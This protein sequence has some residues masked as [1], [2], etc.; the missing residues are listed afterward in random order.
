MQISWCS[1]KRSQDKSRSH[2]SYKRTNLPAYIIYSYTL[3]QPSARIK[4]WRSS[5]PTREDTSFVWMAICIRR[6]GATRTGS[7]GSTI[8]REQPGVLVDSQLRTRMGTFGLMW[9]TTIQQTRQELR[10]PSLQTLCRDLVAERRSVADF[11]GAVGHCVRLEWIS[12]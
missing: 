9:T 6:R 7:G 8:G 5:E 1:D 10:S 12:M 2:H 3:L 11:L 4:S